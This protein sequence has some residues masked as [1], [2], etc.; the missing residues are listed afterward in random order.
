MSG[1]EAS[2]HS[3]VVG[4]HRRFSELEEHVKSLMADT[5]QASERMIRLEGRLDVAEAKAQAAEQREQIT[6][7]HVNDS[8][9]ATNDLVKKLFDKFD[10]NKKENEAH[11]VEA[12]KDQ[13]RVLIWVIVTCSSVLI[14]IGML[15]FSKVFGA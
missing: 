7:M 13:R 12:L 15:M 2:T 10:A 1:E 11:R 9:T 6:Y 3:M 4:L 5:R 8:L 14:S